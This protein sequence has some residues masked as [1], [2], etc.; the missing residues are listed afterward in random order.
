MEIKIDRDE[1][2]RSVA[3]AQSIL[4]RKSNMPILST[5]L[6]TAKNGSL[7]VSATD[8]E[9]G[10][11]QEVP[12]QV[13][14]EGTI[15]ISGRKLFEILKEGKREVIH[16]KE[17]ENNWVFITDGAA[18]FNLASY[19]ADEYPVFLEPEEVHLLEIP[20]DILDE[21]VQK[22]IYAVSMEETGFKLSG[23]FIQKV[24]RQGRVFLRMVATDGHRLSLVDK[25]VA[26]AEN[27]DVG[28][29]I[30][31]PKKGMLE[32]AKMA[33][34]GGMVKV[35]FKDKSCVARKDKAFLVIRLLESKFPD[36]EAVIPK[37][38]VF[39]VGLA[40]NNLLEAMRRMLILSN[41]RYRAV[42]VAFENNTMELVSTNPDLGDAQENL[43]VTFGA[44][45]VEAGFNPRYFVDIL[46]NMESDEVILGFSDESKPCVLR[47][48]ADKGFLGLIMPM[49][50]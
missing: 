31:V 14:T 1:L 20:G 50:L 49:R 2:Y 22:T 37:E 9:L 8:L 10:F 12:V 19:P 42:K 11:Q 35:G 46:Q 16:I 38:P 40:R 13:I 29:G 15:T 41:E 17:K 26:G 34:E 30:M 24:S 33:Q 28:N 5:V 45:R 18:R 6:L 25:T 44:D 43:E 21:M 23:V 48:E 3:R 32:L 47:G 36:Y 27:L 7:A 39:S 4:E